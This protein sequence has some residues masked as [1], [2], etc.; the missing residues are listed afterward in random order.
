VNTAKAT[1]GQAGNDFFHLKSPFSGSELAKLLMNLF[2]Y[3]GKLMRCL[4]HREHLSGQLRSAR[5]EIIGS[6]LLAHA[7]E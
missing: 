5:V 2:P 1:S 6:E 4:F 7:G 3:T